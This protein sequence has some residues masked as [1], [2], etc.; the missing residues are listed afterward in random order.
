[1]L[2]GSQRVDHPTDNA[3]A[4]APLSVTFRA[5]NVAYVP[6]AQYSDESVECKGQLWVLWAGACAQFVPDS[7]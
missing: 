4:I 5:L 7:E 2:A 6:A 3:V 1:M